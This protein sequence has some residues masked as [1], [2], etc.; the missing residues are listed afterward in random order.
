MK[1]DRDMILKISQKRNLTTIEELLEYIDFEDYKGEIISKF[2]MIN[3]AKTKTKFKESEIASMFD[4]YKAE[5]YINHINKG[6]ILNKAKCINLYIDKWE[7]D[8]TI[9]DKWNIE[10]F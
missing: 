8:Y 3:K 2:N 6:R 4:R 5:L 9:S 1:L 7:S 10:A